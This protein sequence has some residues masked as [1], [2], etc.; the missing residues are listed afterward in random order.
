MACCFETIDFKFKDW[1]FYS[2]HGI[3]QSRAGVPLTFDQELAS[4][5]RDLFD[6]R[7]LTIS[8]DEYLIS[9]IHCIP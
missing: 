1:Q 5:P 2:V 9:Y 7:S 6:I 4:A 3:G 8:A